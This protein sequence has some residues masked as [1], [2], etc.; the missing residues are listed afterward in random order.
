MSILLICLLG[1][2][3]FSCFGSDPSPGRGGDGCWAP[4]PG[5]PRSSPV[6]GGVGGC[7]GKV[8]RAGLSWPAEPI[9]TL[10]SF[11]PPSAKYGGRHTVTM[12]PGDGIGPELMLHVKS[13][14]RYTAPRPA[15]CTPRGGWTPGP[16]WGGRG[17]RTVPRGAGSPEARWLGLCLSTQCASGRRVISPGVASRCLG[18]CQTGLGG[19]KV[20]PVLLTVVEF[21]YRPVSW[22]RWSQSPVSQIQVRVGSS[23]GGA[24][25]P[26][27]P[28]GLPRGP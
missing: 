15:S 23:S 11:Q 18:S 5:A 3:A 16:P 24:S 10:P 4:E 13:V 8:P 21:K 6:W 12:I 19:G 17:L 9:C 26:S 28:S 14:F 22:R 25:A 27:G 2:G 1:F 20:L 7:C